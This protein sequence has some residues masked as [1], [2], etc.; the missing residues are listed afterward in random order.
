MPRVPRWS[1]PFLPLLLV[2]ASAVAADPSGK[3]VERLRHRATVTALVFAPDGK[4]L[5]SADEGGNVVLW[6]T[7]TGLPRRRLDG[8]RSR[9]ST[10][11][12]SPDG[13]LLASGC[14]DGTLFLWT[15][16]TG[17]RLLALEGHDDWVMSVAFAPDGK[18]LASGSYDQTIRLWAVPSGKALQV[19]KGHAQ[20]VSGVAFSPDG[21]KLAAVDYEG[22]L[23][24]WDVAAG[25][26]VFNVHHRR[27][28][29]EV[30]GVAFCAAGRSVVTASPA[31]GL[32]FWSPRTGVVERRESPGT[33]VAA[34][35]S[36]ADGKTLIAGA[37][38]GT[39]A[40]LDA[41]TGG[42]VLEFPG[43]VGGGAL[44]VKLPDGTAGAVRAVALSAAGDLAA[45]GGRG[46][47]VRIWKVA[48]LLRDAQAGDELTAAALNKLWDD[49]ASDAP[50]AAKAVA[51][52][53]R[54]PD[55]AVALL[56]EKLR[57]PEIPDRKKI[58]KL[59]DDLDDDAFEVREKATGELEK[60]LPAA[61]G[62]L[63]EVMA[64]TRSLEVKVRLERLLEPADE[65]AVADRLRQRRA[66]QA[67]E[68]MK[69]AEARALLET[70]A[71]RAATSDLADDAAAALRRM[72]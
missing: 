55:K 28:S 39:V 9:V 7:A 3:E 30:F 57:P 49:L 51:R 4:T 50:V 12:F 32:S 67:L 11:A 63:R 61:A 10:L 60:S 15:A 36:S 29:I 5:A 24:I 45:A 47:Q 64:K 13:K 65:A 35:G 68:R 62:L 16:A 40:L 59:I 54:Q 46:G 44:E 37:I 43:H 33:C 31:L 17:K 38:D 8:H 42:V 23:R 19:L 56:K 34:L 41:D 69:A 70:L 22:A 14:G 72:K 53:T 20:A 25:K 52:L 21:G 27:K 6:D 2:A 66:V 58:L 18:T 48:D 71:K 26:V 1:T